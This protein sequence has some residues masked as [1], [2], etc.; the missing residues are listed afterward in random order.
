MIT[1][2]KPSRQTIFD[3]LESQKDLSFSYPEVGDTKNILPAGYSVINQ[4]IKLGH[5]K[6]IFDK[7]VIALQQWKTFDFPWIELCWPE[8][9]LAKGRTVGVLIKIFGLWF[10]NFSQ[11]VY[12]ID[13]AHQ[14]GFAYGTLP[15]HIEV[16]EE[17]FLIERNL[18]DDSVWYKILSFSHPRSFLLRF[19]QP[20]IKR[21]QLR[22]VRC[23]LKAVYDAV[24]SKS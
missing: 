5:G 12:T 8:T 7:A 3:C 10:L 2:K 14:F 9:L 17:L 16:G 19:I 20:I 23:S 15:H 22:F 11:I 18:R 13:E 6:E 21:F 24:N 1:F 4:K